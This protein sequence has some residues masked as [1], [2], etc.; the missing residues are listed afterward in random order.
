M[1]TIFQLREKAKRKRRISCPP[2]VNLERVKKDRNVS[3]APWT[4]FAET[5]NEVDD[6]LSESAGSEIEL[7]LRRD[8]S[9]D[10]SDAGYKNKFR[11]GSSRRQNELDK[12][13]Q[14]LVLKKRQEMKRKMEEAKR[15]MEEQERQAEEKRELVRNTKQ[16][17]E[18][19]IT[20]LEAVVHYLREK[21]GENK[22]EDQYSDWLVYGDLTGDR[23]T[24]T[25]NPFA[26]EEEVLGKMECIHYQ[27]Y[28]F[29]LL[30]QL[31]NLEFQLHL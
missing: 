6:P 26:K 4:T 7:P 29:D 8:P 16:Q 18:N 14:F 3:F 21:V 28:Y 15:A 27:S 9:R 5:I 2:K 23:I 13:R 19:K 22:Q 17:A 25:L 20:R 31:K 11:K 1:N 24:R 12:R 30:L 10:L